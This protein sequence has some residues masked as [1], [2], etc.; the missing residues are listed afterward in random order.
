MWYVSYKYN[1]N[2]FDQETDSIVYCKNSNTTR[3]KEVKSK[4][5]AHTATT[6]VF[7]HMCCHHEDDF[8]FELS[9]GIQFWSHKRGNHYLETYFYGIY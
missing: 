7:E 9:D 4:A 1:R 8:F 2:T 5:K 6:D 3:K